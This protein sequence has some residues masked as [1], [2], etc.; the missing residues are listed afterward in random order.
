MMRVY[1][2]SLQLNSYVC[3]GGRWDRSAGAD[4]GVEFGDAMRAPWRSRARFTSV[5]R[6]A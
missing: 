4:R 2:C 6:R 5:R 1:A 3:N